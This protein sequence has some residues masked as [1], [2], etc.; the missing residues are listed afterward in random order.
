MKWGCL[1]RRKDLRNKEFGFSHVKFE[2]VIKIS[3]GKSRD[4]WINKSGVQELENR[5]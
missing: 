1:W 3:T 4:R 2:M 5:I